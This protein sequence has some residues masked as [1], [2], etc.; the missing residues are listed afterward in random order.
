MSE[1]QVRRHTQ[2]QHKHKQEQLCTSPKTE[3]FPSRDS[4]FSASVMKNCEPCRFDPSFTNDNVPRLACLN[5]FSSF[6]RKN[7]N[8]SPLIS[9][10]GRW[11]MQWVSM[12]AR[13][14]SFVTAHEHPEDTTYPQTDSPPDPRPVGSP[15]W[16]TKFRCWLSA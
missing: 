1:Q 2:L 7:R 10:Q 8:C 13:V 6:F 5:L 4:R 12:R 9:L 14:C 3:C 15:V 11:S 16:A